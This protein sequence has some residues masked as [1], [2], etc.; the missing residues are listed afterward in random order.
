MDDFG[1]LPIFDRKF[2]EESK[3]FRKTLNFSLKGHFDPKRRT[4]DNPT[5]S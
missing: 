3:I 5:I 2:A 4:Y 1:I